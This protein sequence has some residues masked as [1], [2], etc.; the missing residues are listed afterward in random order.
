MRTVALGARGRS[1]ARAGHAIR[2]A[3]AGA[4]VGSFDA[5]FPASPLVY[6]IY[7]DQPHPSRLDLP[8]YPVPR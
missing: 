6:E 4:D 2:L 5:P 8:T 3:I 1:P 7:R